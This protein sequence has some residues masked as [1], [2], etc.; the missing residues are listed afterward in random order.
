MSGQLR[1]AFASNMPAATVEV[2]SPEMEVV[3]RFML[4]AGRSRTVEVPSEA[5]FL[6]VHLPSGQVV[7]LQD[8]GN[9]NREV[10]M[11]EILMGS[12]L[13]S[14][15]GPTGMV[16]PAPTP[17][18]S[19]ADVD[20]SD[21]PT[22]RELRRYHRARSTAAP[23]PT[24]PPE[25][26]LPLAQHGMARLIGPGGQTI[27]G[28]SAS[29]SREAHWNVQGLPIHP[30]YQLRIEQPSGSVLQVQVPATVRRVWA[31]ADVLREQSTVSLS[32]RIQTASDAADMLAGYLQRGDL[33]S[34][35]AMAEWCDEASGMLQS[36]VADPY[37]A[38]VG[39]YLLLR[40]KRF[41]QMHDWGRNLA[42]WF[43]LLPDGCVVWASQ[44]MQQP[45]SDQIQ[46]RKYLLESVQRGMPVY[47]EGLRLL[48]D[49]LRLMGEEGKAAREKVRAATGVV[50][51]DSPVTASV[52][53]T[54][55]YSRNLNVP[56]VVYDIAFAARA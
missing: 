42:D 31:R 1:V 53:T 52:H 34:A 5:S 20:P 33:Y 41:S 16:A 37:A 39:A 48:T 45:A 50:I 3:E 14:R 12:S 36:K 46:I 4:A 32:I 9:M 10:S 7:T 17:P 43:P 40:L 6:R 55:T 18:A 51:W 56:G 13:R 30:P 54:D 19:P 22:P 2:V 15:S 47:T 38:V 49:G 24:V 23:D 29:R 35:E 26:V 28:L 25:E 11:E 27:P 44:L 8:P 21:A